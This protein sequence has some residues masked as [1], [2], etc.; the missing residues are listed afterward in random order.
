MWIVQ[1]EIAEKNLSNLPDLMTDIKN[2]LGYG[3][4]V[5]KHSRIEYSTI[6]FKVKTDNVVLFSIFEQVKKRKYIVKL[7]VLNVLE[8]EK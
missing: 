7:S 8:K 4:E 5:T 3:G 2:V 1:A 6:A